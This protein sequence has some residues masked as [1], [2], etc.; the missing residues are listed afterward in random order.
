MMYRSLGLPRAVFVRCRRRVGPGVLLRSLGAT[1]PGDR[2]SPPRPARLLPP[3]FNVLR[4]A[5][6]KLRH[7]PCLPAGASWFIVDARDLGF[8]HA[9]GPV[10]VAA[11]DRRL[12]PARADLP[13]ADRRAAGGVH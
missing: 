5:S 12:A 4:R 3:L 2:R 9:G 8:E 6:I 10:G 7:D 1:R 13:R 11:A